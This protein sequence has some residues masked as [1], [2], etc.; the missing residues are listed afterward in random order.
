MDFNDIVYDSIKNNKKI[1]ISCVLVLCSLFS[2][3]II[4]PKLCSNFITTIPDN[5]KDFDFKSVIYVLLPYFFSE[6]AYYISDN[7]DAQ[8][9][10]KIELSITHQ[11]ISKIMNSLKTTKKNINMNE[12]IL[13]IKRIFDIRNMYHLILSYVIPALFVSVGIVFYFFKANKKLGIITFIILFL[14]F[15]SLITMGKKCFDKIDSHEEYVNT[16]CDDVHDVLNNIDD[17]VISGTEN[18][19]M[20][21][22][23]TSQDGL[24]KTC[25]AKELCNSNLKFIFS[26]VYMVIMVTLNG[27]ALK[28]YFSGE[29]SKSVL[30]TIFFMVLILVQLYD[31]MLYE[32]QNILS[33]IGNYNILKHYFNTFEIIDK[34]DLPNIILNNFDISANN[35]KLNYDDKIIFDNFN[36]N[37]KQNQKTG[38]IGE[39]GSGKSSLLKILCNIIPY[40]GNIFINN[41]NTKEF[42]NESLMKYISYIPQNPI[43]FNRSIYENLNYGSEYTIDEIQQ[44]IN[45]FKI[46]DL[47]KSFPSGLSTIAGKNGEKLS[48]G[49][50]QLIYILRAI[51]QNKQIILL[52]EPTSALDHNYKKILIELLNKINKTIIIITHDPEIYEI[53]DRIVTLEKGIIIKDTHKQKSIFY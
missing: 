29:M 19:E 33:S 28:E 37:F 17:I 30:I 41:K 2:S 11:T 34:S 49:Q 21:I 14:A 46:Q 15:Y 53:F 10:P 27:F 51:I 42:N 35:I 43:L 8:T 52:D 48:G 47:I 50:R 12:L 36:I 7:I 22:I 25:V 23:K 5:I 18:K 44:F 32:L 31:S 24:Y 3:Q 4:F 39:I 40:Q 9:I 20:Q 6:I 13:H 38:I 45:N 26:F 16:Y 1:I